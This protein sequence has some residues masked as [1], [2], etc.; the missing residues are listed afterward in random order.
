MDCR[1]DHHW[2]LIRIV[3]RDALIH[4]KKITVELFDR[5]LTVTLNRVAEIEEYT[6]TSASDAATFVTGFLRC[7]R[8]NVPRCKITETRVFTLKEV[9]SLVLGH[10]IWVNFDLADH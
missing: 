7:S 1:K 6:E 8:G 2:S 5:I 3:T 4:V 10:R 9:I